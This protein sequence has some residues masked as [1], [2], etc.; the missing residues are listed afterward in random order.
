MKTAALKI[1]VG[2]GIGARVNP[3]HRFQGRERILGRVGL[4]HPLTVFDEGVPDITILAGQRD[5]AGTKKNITIQ[6]DI[7]PAQSLAACLSW[8]CKLA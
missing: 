5:G 7:P 1:G 8:D 3:F 4:G 6:T 2:P